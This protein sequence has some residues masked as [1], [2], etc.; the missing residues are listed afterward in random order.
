MGWT[1]VYQFVRPDPPTVAELAALGAL[2]RKAN[3]DGWDGESFGL[4]IRRE[5]SA[6]GVIAEGMSKL[7][8][9]LD[10]SDDAERMVNAINAVLAA[11]PEARVRLFDDYGFFG[12]DESGRSTLTGDPTEKP[13][14]VAYGELVALSELVPPVVTL[15]PTLRKALERMGEHKPEM[16]HKPTVIAQALT[17]HATLNDDD[18]QRPQIDALLDSVPLVDR[19][20]VGMCRYGS[21]AKQNDVRCHVLGLV[22]EVARLGDVGPLV[23]PFLAA[24]RKPRGLYY[25]G[26]MGLADTTIVRLAEHADVRR[27]MA[28]D[29]AESED[30]DANEEMPFRRAEKAAQFLAASGEPTA[31]AQLVELVRRYRNADV[32]WRLRLYTLDAAVEALG[33]FPHPAALA[34]LIRE[35]PRQFGRRA[36]GA[37]L[38]GIARLSPERALP[39]LRRHLDTHSHVSTVATALAAADTAEARAELASLLAHYPLFYVQNAVGHALGVAPHQVE[40]PPPE[41]RLSHLDADVRSWAVHDLVKQGDRSLFVSAVLAKGLNNAIQQRDKGTQ[42]HTSWGDWE[43]DMPEHI[44]YGS[45]ADQLA[46]ANGEGASVFGPQ[47]ILDAVAP[48]L[49]HG[50]AAVAATFPTPR[51]E[52]SDEEVTAL[53][54]EEAASLA[55]LVSSRGS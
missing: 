53:D 15:P 23:K 49:Q 13:I 40:I 34:T 3:A 1:I 21:L 28:A 18:P 20:V 27:Q 43:E 38:A 54:L 6:D 5:A 47:T 4:A 24:W 52:L 19:A 48:V 46:W 29:V 16:A 39:L 7:G 36:G 35:L 37:A 17:A 25:Y 14:D 8:M 12:I 31:I 26:D 11:L 33:K 55:A 44:R 22:D 2:V 50:V 9:S 51:F 32:T 42:S 30:A 10:E 45:L 41:A